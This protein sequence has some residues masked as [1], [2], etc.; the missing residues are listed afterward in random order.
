M[1]L[2]TTKQ[3]LLLNASGLDAVTNPMHWSLLDMVI[4]AF[5]YASIMINSILEFFR[6]NWHNVNQLRRILTASVLNKLYGTN[7]HLP[8]YGD[9]IT[10]SK[11]SNYGSLS[12]SDK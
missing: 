2:C 1:V 9:I 6:D 4:T 10:T 8:L 11:R 5:L 3:V 7:M 12:D